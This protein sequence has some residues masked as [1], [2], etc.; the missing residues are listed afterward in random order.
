MKRKPGR[1]ETRRIGK[2]ILRLSDLQ[3]ATSAVLNSF[4]CPNAQRG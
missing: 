4:S 2:P 3:V 1:K